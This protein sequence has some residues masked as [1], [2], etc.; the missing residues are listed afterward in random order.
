MKTGRSDVNLGRG[1]FRTGGY[2]PS[3][4]CVSGIPQRKSRKGQIVIDYRRLNKLLN[5]RRNL[6]RC[7]ILSVVSVL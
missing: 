1:D 2:K 4:P 7:C 3:I 6:Q 5:I